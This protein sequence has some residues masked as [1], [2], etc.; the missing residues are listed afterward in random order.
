MTISPRDRQEVRSAFGYCCGYC[1]VSELD[2]GGELQ[3]DHYQPAAKGGSDDRENL[4]YA[5]VHC[6]RFK[7]SYWVEPDLADSFQLLH[8]AL[9]DLSLHIQVAPNGRLDGLTPRGWTHIRR[10]HLNRNQLVIWRQTRLHVQ[11]LENALLQTEETAS[12]LREQ[13][14]KL[15]RE[16]AQLRRQIARLS[17]EA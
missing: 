3:I 17:G 5:C 7:G 9:D 2:I 8:P 13:I 16:V 11:E 14:Q 10:L 12:F 4:V 6:N 15:E 1:G